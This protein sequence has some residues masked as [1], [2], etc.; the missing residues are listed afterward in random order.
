MPRHDPKERPRGVHL[1][2]VAQGLHRDGE[3]ERGRRDPSPE[4]PVEESHRVLVALR[5][6]QNIQRDVVRPGRGLA[7]ERVGHFV[8]HLGCGAR[9]PGAPVAAYED[10]EQGFSEDDAVLPGAAEEVDCGGEL[11]GVAELLDEGEV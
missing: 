9:E 8:E 5:V 1:V 10:D 4:H 11:P 6:D 2:G 3:G 7:Q